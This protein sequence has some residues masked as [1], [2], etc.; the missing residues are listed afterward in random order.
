M[1]ERGFEL[2]Y[3]NRV[4]ASRRG[5]DGE[6]RGQ[7]LFGDALFGKSLSQASQM[8]VSQIAKYVV[9]LL[10]YG[11]IDFAHQLVIDCPGVRELVPEIDSRFRPYRGISSRA[12]RFAFMQFDKLLALG[13]YLR[14][15]NQLR[16]D[17]DRSWPIR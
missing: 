8:P 2:L 10:N 4:F 7:L 13:L 11:H 15:T 14:R 1:Y 17:S 12:R 16:G 5:Y 3:L 6:S 9:L